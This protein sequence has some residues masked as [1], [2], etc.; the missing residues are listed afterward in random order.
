MEL[1]NMNDWL[2]SNAVSIAIALIT[3]VSTY[4]VYGYRLSAVESR[5]DRQ[6]TAIAALQQQN[7]DTLIKLAQ[8]Q[9]DIDY[10]KVQIDKIVH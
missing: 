8:I 5:Q 6:G 1:T 3:L 4:A 2:K 9:K 7:T 10:I